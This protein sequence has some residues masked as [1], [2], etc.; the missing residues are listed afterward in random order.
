M[1]SS[2]RSERIND[3]SVTE[4]LGS[5]FVLDAD[6]DETDVRASL[7]VEA[8]GWWGG[9]LIGPADWVAARRCSL[10]SDLLWPI[11]TGPRDWYTR[12]IQFRGSTCA[13]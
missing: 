3:P 12:A 13:G 6:G 7:R 9:D 11:D 5:A 10:C 2:P 1:R 4:Y 8:D